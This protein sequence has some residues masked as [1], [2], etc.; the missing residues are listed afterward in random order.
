MFDTYLFMLTASPVDR[1]SRI[2]ELHFC[3]PVRPTSNECLGYDTKQSDGEALVM[4]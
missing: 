4:T 3:R 1:D 2:Y